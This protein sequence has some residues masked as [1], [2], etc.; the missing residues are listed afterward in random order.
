MPISEVVD[1]VIQNCPID[2]RRGLYKV[3]FHQ[4]FQ[5]FHLISGLLQC[6]LLLFSPPQNIVLSGGSTMFRDFGKKL[7][8]DVKR[9]VD[10][11]LKLSEQLSGGLAK[12][13]PID[14]EV[15]SH[16]MQRYAVWFGGSV[17]A[18]SVSTMYNVEEIR[19]VI[20]KSKKLFHSGLLRSN[21]I[22]TSNLLAKLN[23]FFQRL[24]LNVVSPLRNVEATFC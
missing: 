14:V 17:L 3:S 22:L 5:S 10:A 15:V 11:R 4:T 19:F 20:V 7:Q 9:T 21:I 8:R 24:S 12:P 18:A 16:P 13:K 6:L 23:L 2:V 1:N